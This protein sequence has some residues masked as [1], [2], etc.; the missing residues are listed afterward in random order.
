M[1][2]WITTIPSSAASD[3]TVQHYASTFGWDTN[4]SVQQNYASGSLLDQEVYQ[5][6]SSSGP[7][8]QEIQNIYAGYNWWDGSS[9]YNSCNGNYSG[10]Y[11]PCEVMLLSSR[12]TQYEG[13]G[14]GNSSAPW[15]EHDYTY[16]DYHPGSGLGDYEC[17]G[18]QEQGSYHNLCQDAVAGTNLPNFANYHDTQGNTA[19][20]VTHTWTYQN[21]NTTV[22]GWVYYDVNK[23]V[24]SQITD[25]QGNIFDCQSFAY[26]QNANAGVPSPAA[27]YVTTT[28]W[29]HQSACTPGNFGTPAI[30]TYAGY[31]NDGNQLMSVDGVGTA[32]SSFYGSSG[33]SGMNGCTLSGTP[34]IYNTAWSAGTYTSCTTYD[35]T[36]DLPTSTTNAF[37]QTTHTSSDATQHTGRQ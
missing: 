19:F 32:H 29:Y 28:N 5:G 26:D 35:G 15:V 27:G 4:Q 23:A 11:T 17:P 8:L 21:N 13:T 37:G 36:S 3:L 31:D 25:S 18:E 33:K 16:D 12:T 30:T 7:L 24:S 34:P 10:I 6:N 2:G 1:T 14:S 22:N 9:T 20:D